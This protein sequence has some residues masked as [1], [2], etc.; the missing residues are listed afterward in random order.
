MKTYTKLFV[1]AG[2]LILVILAA[3]SCTGNWDPPYEELNKSGYTVSVEFDAN[4]GIFAGT[5]DVSIIDVYDA[6]SVTANGGVYLLS[7]DDPLRAEGAFS[8]SRSGYFLAGWYTE[9][10]LR[11]DEN[12][13]PLDE[14]G[15]STEVSGRP[16]GYIYSGLWDFDTDK[17]F[18]ETAEGLSSE[19]P[20]RTLYAAWIPYF[21]YEFYT[22][23]ADGNI[24]LLDRLNAIDLKLPEWSEK[25]GKLTTNSFPLRDGYTFDSV[26]LSA[27]LSEPL[28]ENIYGARAYVDYERGVTDVEKVSV[29]TTWLE[30]SWFKIYNAEQFYTNSRLDGNYIL[31]N[32]IDFSDNVWSPTLSK[33]KFTGNIIGNGYKISNVNVVQGDSSQLFGG[34]FGSLE[35]CA[36]LQEVQFENVTYEISAGSRMQGASFG[37]LAGIVSNDAVL[38]GVQI[39]GE[40]VIGADC[41][42]QTG[43]VVG[44]LCGSGN[45]DIDIS[46]IICRADESAENIT[47]ETESDGSVNIYFN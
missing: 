23:D 15:V 40:L 42:P 10:Q 3:T 47:V 17:L 45:T 9:R 38:E 21:T 43:Y 6:Q 32:D 41:F 19:T 24:T 25:T 33:G 13:T 2:L 18:L 20:C 4:G 26:F 30:G 46:D 14:F 12:G 37:V 1:T 11:T 36:V 44:L 5:N 39:S 29:Y 8:I 27:D 7:P 31:C 22:S 28:T 16:Q 35:A 34:L